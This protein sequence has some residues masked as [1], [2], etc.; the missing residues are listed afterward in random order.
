M[1]LASI[2]VGSNS[3]RLLIG[4]VRGRVIKVLFMDRVVTRLAGGL[5]VSSMLGDREMQMTLE[6]LEGFRRRAWVLGARAIKAVATS[7]I[8]EAR[9]SE[10]FLKDVFLKTGLE[11]EVISGDI[12]AEL[13]VLGVLSGLNVSSAL[14]VD[15]GG[16]STEWAY[17][18]DGRI[19]SK[20]S[21]P[22]G[23]VKLYERHIHSEPPS[24]AD[25]MSLDLE[26]DEAA[27]LIKNTAGVLEPDTEFI[28]TAGTAST[29]ASLD[30]SIE[31]YDRDLIHN[32]RIYIDRL[33]E[34]SQ[35]LIS[36]N[37]K[38]RATLRGL[39]PSRADLIIP[40]INFTIK[41][42]EKF[43]FE[44]VTISETGLLEGALLNLAKE[45]QD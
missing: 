23:V 3:V 20:G 34:I 31:R 4:E 11:I 33:K 36:L 13:T 35:K 1:V 14:I 9:N 44:K 6:V 5:S 27:S 24:R 32:H 29:L 16:G 10:E 19:L 39:E 15:I 37:I 25:I 28:A 12:E 22:T 38:E 21:I 7:A 42:M 18:K 30:L 8:R 45:V 43:S 26:I 40:G 41:I 2:D 17:S